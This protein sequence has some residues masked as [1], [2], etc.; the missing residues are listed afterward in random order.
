MKAVQDMQDIKDMQGAQD[1]D[2]H[3]GRAGGQD[4][5]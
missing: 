3:V 1:T 2:S 4:R 5:Q